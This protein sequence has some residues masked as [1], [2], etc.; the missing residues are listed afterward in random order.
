MILGWYKLSAKEFNKITKTPKSVPLEALL[1]IL[2]EIFKGSDLCTDKNLE[3]FSTNDKIAMKTV[4][5]WHALLL[6]KGLTW[7]WSGVQLV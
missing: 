4:H 5:H 6:L 2:A 7:C 3:S 1:E